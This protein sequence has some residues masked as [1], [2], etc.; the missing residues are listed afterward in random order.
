MRGYSRN[1]AKKLGFWQ[2]NLDRI[3]PEPATHQ[4]FP[5]GKLVPLLKDQATVYDWADMPTQ[6][7]AQRKT[8]PVSEMERFAKWSPLRNSRHDAKDFDCKDKAWCLVAEVMQFYCTDL[9]M[10]VLKG[11]FPWRSE[12][13]HAVAFFVAPDSLIW[14]FDGTDL[15]I[16]KLN[17]ECKVSALVAL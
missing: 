11:F 13:S 10:G 12:G 2:R 1:I 9:A 5:M 4:L 14:A 15:E 3:L 7:V 6:L 8:I 17:K 16:R